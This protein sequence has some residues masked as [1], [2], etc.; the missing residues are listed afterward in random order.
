M[1]LLSADWNHWPDDLS[2]AEI[3]ETAARLGV[4]GLELGVYDTQVELAPDRIAEWNRLGSPQ[5]VGIRALLYSMPPERW[6]GGGLAAPTSRQRF[7]EQM[8]EFLEIASNLG[9]R[10]VG[11][12]PGADSAH[13]D[14][15]TF[16]GLLSELSTMAS[17][18]DAGIAIEPKPETMVATPK[19][20]ATLSGAI[21]KPEAVGLLLDTGHEF[22]AGR[23]PA[24]IVGSLEVQLLHVH[25]GDS[26][27]DP[28]ADLPPGR[29]H[30]LDDFFD[31][32]VTKGYQGAMSPDAYGAV[33]AGVVTS[34]EALEETVRCLSNY[35]EGRSS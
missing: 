6:P 20:V 10:T 26:D 2:R 3:V 33:E 22:A 1:E 17:N 34:V 27:G 35:Q 9:L 8:E 5:G 14:R 31:A 19:D 32:L 7:L 12:W 15:R 21:A 25:L 30:P 29:I 4:A 18:R 24:V 16:A 13:A 28:D 23:D 11:L